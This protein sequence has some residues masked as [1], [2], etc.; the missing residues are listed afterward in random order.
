MF[1]PEDRVTKG[2]SPRKAETHNFLVDFTKTMV[3]TLEW[4][5]FV[6]HAFWLQFNLFRKFVTMNLTAGENMPPKNRS[7]PNC[8]MNLRHLKFVFIFLVFHLK[9][10]DKYKKY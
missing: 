4:F 6:G 10:K 1:H 8:V 7:V 2:S 3:A 5:A 9:K